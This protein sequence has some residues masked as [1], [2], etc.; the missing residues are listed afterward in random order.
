MNDILKKVPGLMWGSLLMVMFFVIFAPNYTNQRNIINILQNSAIII[1]V[2]MGM[3]LTILSGQIDMSIGGVMTASA[4]ISAMYFAHIQNPNAL[5]ILV[6]FLIGIGVG[7]VFGFLNGIL[8]AR[9]KFN[10]WLVTF[11]MMSISYGIAQVVTGGKVISGFSKSFRNVT[12]FSLAG[13]PMVV[14]IA[15]IVSLLMFFLT[16]KT[17]FG[18]HMY[19]VGASEKCA[20]QSG[21]RVERIR[22]L[23]Y[24]LS[25][26]LSGFGGVLL[27]SKT[28]F[29]SANVA[30]GQEFTAMANVIIGGI[31][32]DGG[33]GG[34]LGAF[35]GSIILTAILN[36]L[37][38]MGLSN[39]WQQVFTGVFILLIIIIDVISQRMKKTKNTR[40]VYKHA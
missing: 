26:L 33:K 9:Y 30:S 39:Y 36:G 27:V 37:Q 40:R 29:A 28:N 6:T 22:F 16:Y 38:L 24:L 23:I 8:I 31:S 35:A 17:K 34:L 13:I 1:I 5:D 15:V 32:F 11:A 12:R 10:F 7:S 2:S 20:A 4:V 19:A 25:G 3:G 21:I 14:Y 18:M